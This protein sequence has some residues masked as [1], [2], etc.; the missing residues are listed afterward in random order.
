MDALASL[1]WRSS[2]GFSHDVA[3]IVFLQDATAFLDA[4]GLFLLFLFSWS[5]MKM[6]F[7]FSFTVR[8]CVLCAHQ[9]ASQFP[10]GKS[11]VTN[12]ARFMLRDNLNETT[13]EK[14]GWKLEQKHEILRWMWF[15]WS[16]KVTASQIASKLKQ[17]RPI[18]SILRPTFLAFV[19]AIIA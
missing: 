2:A 16:K 14:N 9:R 1:W 15:L 6:T 13:W 5:T 4:V 8:A 18:K 19:V 7:F 11:S 12:S 10:I 3:N 17:K